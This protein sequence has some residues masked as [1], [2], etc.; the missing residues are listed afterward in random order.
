MLSL[1]DRQ[2][3]VAQATSGRVV[4]LAGPGSGKTATLVERIRRLL[5][6][7]ASA[8]SIAA[9]TFTVRAATELEERLDGTRLGFCGTIHGFAREILGMFPDSTPLG[10]DFSVLDEDDVNDLYRA[11]HAELHLKASLSKCRVRIRRVL[12]GTTDPTAL[13]VEDSPEGID[14]RRLEVGYRAA[15][16]RLRATDFDGLIRHARILLLENPFA[17]MQA[18]NAFRHVSVDEAQDLDWTQDHLIDLVAPEDDALPGT[19]RSLLMVGDPMQSIYSWRGGTP[20]VLARRVERAHTRVMLG[21]NFRSRKGIVDLANRVAAADPLR[22]EDYE[23]VHVREGT[24]RD[25]WPCAPF[26]TDA[27]EIDHLVGMIQR[28]RIGGLPLREIAVL[29]RANSTLAVVAERLAAGGVAFQHLGARKARLESDVCRGAMAYLRLSLNHD[30]DL[31]LARALR[32]PARPE[33][34]ARRD[35]VHRMRAAAAGGSSFDALGRA[36]AWADAAELDAIDTFLGLVEDLEGPGLWVSQVDGLWSFLQTAHRA[37]GLDS[38]ADDLAWMRELLTMF[39]VEHAPG[40]KRARKTISGFLWWLIHGQGAGEH[41]PEADAVTLSTIHLAK[42]LEWPTVFVPGLVERVFPTAPSCNA[43]IA[44]NE[45]AMDEERRCFFVAST[46]AKDCLVLTR[47]SRM[48]DVRDGLL[49]PAVES[50]FL[51]FA[52]SLVEDA[53]HE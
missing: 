19:D 20:A 39:H 53:A 47:C 8:R 49:Y 12:L 7:G 52:T 13:P 42:G 32:C 9:C 30:D 18:R 38:R 34:V 45:A 6:A 3:A 28:A 21:H 40:S 11:C 43:E 17:R 46:R 25:V 44:G 22:P 15:C 35:F 33:I 4:V 31:A 10:S 26:D 14:A 27:M 2:E 36:S 29:A 48:A 16:A 41:D 50:R 23:L 37:L 1:T 24:A 51:R 5:A